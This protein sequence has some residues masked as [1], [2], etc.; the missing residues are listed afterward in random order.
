MLNQIF[1]FLALLVVGVFIVFAVG[2]YLHFSLKKQ[3]KQSRK[4]AL[5]VQ[6]DEPSE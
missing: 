2:T 1:S 5:K 4:E 6:T 3:N